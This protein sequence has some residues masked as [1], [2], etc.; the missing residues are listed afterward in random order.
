MPLYIKSIDPFVP[1]GS[2]S[3]HT[4]HHLY[5]IIYI[6]LLWYFVTYTAFTLHYYGILQL[7]LYLHYITMVFLQLA[8]CGGG[9]VFIGGCDYM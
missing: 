2:Q 4:L 7:A 9:G 5:Y 3:A 6:T 8:R 1:D